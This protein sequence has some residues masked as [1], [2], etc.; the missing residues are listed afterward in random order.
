M[1]LPAHPLTTKV[2]FNQWLSRLSSF[3]LCSIALCSMTGLMF[4]HTASAQDLSYAQAEQHLLSESYTSQAHH[5]LQQASQLEADAVKGL[6]LPRIDLNVRAYAFHNKVDVPLENL[7]NNLEDTLNQ[8]VNQQVDEWQTNQNIQPDLTGSLK[9]GLYG[10]VQN[11]VG[12]IPN[13]ANITL[14]DQVVKPT[15]SLLMPIYTG[16]LTSSVKEMANIKAARSQLNEQQQQD[17][18]RFELI[19]SYFNVQL[20]QKL[21]DASRFNLNSTQ[22]HYNNALKLEQQ[23]MISKGQRMQFEVARNNAERTLQNVSSNLQSSIFQLNNLLHRDQIAKL[24][25]PLFVNTTQSQALNTLLKS[26]QDESA[27]IRKLQMD[28]QLAGVNIKAKSAA[29]KPTLFAFGE[30]GLDEKNNWMVGVMA[31]YNLFSGIDNNK[32]IQAAK[33]QQ[34]A[35][36]MMTER[37]KQEVENMIYKSYSEL[38]S[39]Q[40]THELLQRNLGA[41]K[42]NLRIQELSF[43]ESMGT[44]TQVI[45]AQNILNGLESEMAINAYRYVMS[46]AA[47][48]QSH[49]S[50][51]QFQNYV[52]QPNTHFIR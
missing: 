36:E 30:Y 28:I 7:K 22:G 33:L 52:N 6:G 23:G 37:A 41:A 20:Q 32:N 39:A 1:P 44:A 10:A 47:L 17:L 9:E 8:N 18:Q 51:A 3:R 24:S 11:G 15:V 27:L 5:A 16:G 38:S 45:D 50:I 21:Q 14:E 34:H 19:Q 4:S 26:Y 13:S 43:K 2:V 25:T 31:R 12:L 40:H 35:A 29:K 42:E 49:G 46:L 48:L